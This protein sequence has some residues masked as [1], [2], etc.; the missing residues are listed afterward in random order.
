MA[1]SDRRVL[2]ALDHRRQNP[3]ALREALRLADLLG[4]EL[5]AL[6]I[7]DEQLISL[8]GMSFTREI[9]RTSGVVRNLDSHD[10]LRRMA[11]QVRAIR[12]LLA[13]NVRAGRRQISLEVVRGSLSHMALQAPGRHDVVFLSAPDEVFS[14]VVRRRDAGQ[15]SRAPVQVIVDGSAAS[16]GALSL[17]RELALATD[18][19]LL[20]I[21]I[22]DESSNAELIA[23]IQRQ[24]GEPGD[25][26]R[27]MPLAATACL[28]YLSGLFAEDCSMM[29]L[30]ARL[31][32]F[33]D[34]GAG[35]RLGHLNFPVAL[36][37]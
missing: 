9:N 19:P 1:L 18:A 11:E 14:R 25:A 27:I 20:I 5:A 4:G 12:R 8:A 26:A 36:V 30:P 17:A 31:R 34:A 21:S 22:E 6:Y 33:D 13:S 24:V 32:L 23:E 2:I 28:Q 10:L 3:A 16:P 37:R 7:E 35:E 29:V 15:A